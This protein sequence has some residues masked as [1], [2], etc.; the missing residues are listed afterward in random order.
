ME[1]VEDWKPKTGVGDKGSSTDD[2]VTEKLQNNDKSF[3]ACDVNLR[4][5]VRRYTFIDLNVVSILTSITGSSIRLFLTLMNTIYISTNIQYLSVL[6]SF[7]LLC[8]SKHYT[9]S[10]P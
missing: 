6:I 4:P 10:S 9:H 1:G 2:D 7:Q 8:Y 5:R 3:C